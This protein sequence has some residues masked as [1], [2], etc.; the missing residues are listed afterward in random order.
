MILLLSVYMFNHIY[1]SRCIIT[2]H[3]IYI[4]ICV[5]LCVITTNNNTEI[6]IMKK[7]SDKLV[8]LH[9]NSKDIKNVAYLYTLLSVKQL[10]FVAVSLPHP[11]NIVKLANKKYIRGQNGTPKYFQVI[12]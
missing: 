12:N 5:C 11:L 10:I 4:Y 7:C 9:R 3:N 8:Y 6:I 1:T 2:R